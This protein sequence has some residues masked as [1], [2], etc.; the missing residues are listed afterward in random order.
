[1]VACGGVAGGGGGW[2]VDSWKVSN[3]EDGGAGGSEQPDREGHRAVANPDET[4]TTYDVN[5]LPVLT[6]DVNG[7][8]QKWSPGTGV[9]QFSRD[10]QL[11]TLAV[12]PAETVLMVNSLKIMNLENLFPSLPSGK[13]IHAFSGFFRSS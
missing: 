13:I 6:V 7:V 12:D 1:M 9:V 4:Q 3:K 5:N 11:L 2:L 8:V 10:N